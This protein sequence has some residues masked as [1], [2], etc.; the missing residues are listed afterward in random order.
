MVDDTFYA[1]F[2]PRQ[3]KSATD[4]VG[5]FDRD[6]P[7]IRYSVS[8]SDAGAEGA[9]AFTLDSIYNEK[10]N[11]LPPLPVQTPSAI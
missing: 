4:N 3:I 6:N 5:T 1:A 11:P 7:D 9:T 2:S 10:R 8:E